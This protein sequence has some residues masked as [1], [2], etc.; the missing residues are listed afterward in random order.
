MAEFIYSTS[1]SIRRPC[2]IDAEKLEALDVIL[3]EEWARLAKKNEEKL[4]A[5]VEAQLNAK[6]S[7]VELEQLQE[8]LAAKLQARIDGKSSLDEENVNTEEEEV[9][10]K[11]R[12]EIKQKHRDEIRTRLLS[13]T[14]SDYIE[15]RSL[16]IQLK[17]NKKVAL[18]SFG[19]ALRQQSLMDEKPI[20]FDAVLR[21]G[22]VK[23]NISIRQRDTLDIS[24]SPEHLSE[25]REL[26]AALQRWTER[27]RPPKWQ[28]LW[29]LLNPL[30]W[31]LF[32]I[33]LLVSTYAIGDSEASAKKTYKE[34]AGQLLKDGISQDEQ[35]KAIENILSLEAGYVPPTQAKQT[36]GWLCSCYLGDL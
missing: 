28:Q 31:F 16:I 14:Y 15:S 27:I 4:N 29:V 18:K 26:F 19:E 21:N 22:E 32:A 3:D 8:E 24:V 33:I 12:D 7:S 2:L 9:K 34:Q 11:R 25:S 17:K 23:C 30:Q 5:E 1:L 6:H 36:P 35:L 20:G 13:Y 10:Q